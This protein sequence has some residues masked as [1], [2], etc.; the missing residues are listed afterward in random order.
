MVEMLRHYCL[1]IILIFIGYWVWMA[2][3]KGNMSF[4]PGAYKVPVPPNYP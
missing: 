1:I 4:L 2:K 3:K